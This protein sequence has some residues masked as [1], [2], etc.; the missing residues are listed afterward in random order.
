MSENKM[1]RSSMIFI[2]MC[3]KNGSRLK[4]CEKLPVN[5]HGNLHFILRSK[6]VIVSQKTTETVFKTI[7]KD[8]I[9]FSGWA[10]ILFQ[11]RTSL[12]RQ[13]LSAQRGRPRREI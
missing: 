10:L 7:H 9:C 3:E 12:H 13:K 8:N 5:K 4:K 6:E 11:T 2:M 1:Q